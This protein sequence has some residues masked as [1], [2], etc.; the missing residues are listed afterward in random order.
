[1]ATRLGRRPRGGLH[2]L[3]SVTVGRQNAVRRSPF[4]ARSPP[5]VAIGRPLNDPS[6]EE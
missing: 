5:L 2:G 6:L 3:D 1:M 4:I